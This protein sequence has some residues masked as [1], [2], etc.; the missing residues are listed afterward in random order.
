MMERIEASMQKHVTYQLLELA[1]LEHESSPSI[2]N[3]DLISLCKET[4]HLLQPLSSKN[5]LLSPSASNLFLA[6]D[7][8]QVKQV[9]LIILDNG[10]KPV[11]ELSMMA[12]V[13]LPKFCL[14]FSTGSIA[15]TGLGAGKQADLA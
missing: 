9:L 5:I 1:E 8:L 2:S 10:L 6:A 12:S 11:S 15:L 3:F 13:F 4:I 14:S 7:R